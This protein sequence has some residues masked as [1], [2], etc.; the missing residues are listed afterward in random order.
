[1]DS[2][3]VERS[4]GVLTVTLNRPQRKNAVDTELWKGLLK[5]FREAARSEED[6]VVVVTGAGGEFSP[7]PIS[8]TQRPGRPTSWCG[9]A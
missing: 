9:C 4:N 7:E 3:L 5:T 6:R 1:M 2:L 8:A